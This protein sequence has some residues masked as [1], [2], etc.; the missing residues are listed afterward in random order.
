MRNC[1]ELCDIA[2][3][4][5]IARVSLATRICRTAKSLHVTELLVQR[6]LASH[7]RIHSGVILPYIMHT[8]Y[9]LIFFLKDSACC[10]SQMASVLHG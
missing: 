1:N 7:V 5:A 10:M 6:T 8:I 9:C 3:H 4:S 2:C